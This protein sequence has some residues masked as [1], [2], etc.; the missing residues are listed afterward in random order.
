MYYVLNYWFE[1]DKMLSS[2]VKKIRLSTIYKDYFGDYLAAPKYPISKEVF[3]AVNQTIAC[4]TARIGV[5]VY[6]C[7]ECE[8]VKH[9]LRSCKNRFCPTCGYVDTKRW[10]DKMLDKVANCPHH[11]IV[12]TLPGSLRNLSRINKDII[13][14]LLLR[15]TAETMIDWFAAKHQLEPGIMNVLHTA[16]SDQ[17]Y[18]PHVHMICS[19]GGLNCKSELKA[20]KGSWYLI[21]QKFL[22]KKYR[23]H[24]QKGL[25][26]LF[27]KG[28]LRHDYANLIE[29]KK[30]IKEVNTQDW[31]VS[32]Q[33]PL[34][35]ADDIVN[36]VGRYTKRAC[37]SE[38]NIK[39]AS[40]G[41]IRFAY[42]DYK[43][44]DHKGI[45]Q[46]SEVTL[47][48]HDF[49]ARLFE[50]VP[51]KGFR[52]VRY[53]G[54]YSSRKIKELPNQKRR[55]KTQ[56]ADNWRDLQIQKTGKDPL[57]CPCCNKEMVLTYVHYDLK[58]RPRWVQK[59]QLP[60]SIKT[61]LV[62]V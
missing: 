22:S 52:M 45:A 15:S 41:E 43:L 40:N 1:N 31:V 46:M 50:H 56:L 14:S 23:W 39:D 28:E 51:T 48:F 3:K 24:F 8:E 49:F 34:R 12:F 7:K 35:K 6:Q 32:V 53:Y 18:H 59:K 44:A 30:F 54:I 21:N 27:K 38:Y 20:V 16:G 42:K 4:R 19:A 55:N 2:Q 29:F 58:N 5:N 60:K 33:A 62:A 57:I 36:Y 26:E 25:F 13:H 47:S 11:H 9:V 17:K 61:K 10:A 37:I